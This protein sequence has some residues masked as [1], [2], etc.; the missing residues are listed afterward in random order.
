MSIRSLQAAPEPTF[1]FVKVGNVDSGQDEHTGWAG[2]A[3]GDEPRR[4]RART[5]PG[6]R[7][8]ALRAFWVAGLWHALKI[9]EPGIGTSRSPYGLQ[10]QTSLTVLVFSRAHPL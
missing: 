10:R 6:S 1:S 2:I 8:V 4:R 5:G 7:S 3:V 9:A